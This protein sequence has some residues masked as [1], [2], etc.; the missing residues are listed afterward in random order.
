VN[1]A[2]PPHGAQVLAINSGSSSIR[3]AVYASAAPWRRVLFG[4]LERI[5]SVAATLTVEHGD[6]AHAGDPARDNDHADGPTSIR[7]R[8]AVADIAV[9]ALAD[10]S[11][12]AEFLLGWL[13]KAIDM[14]GL[15]AVGHRLVHGFRHSAP[16][17]VD[18][19]LRAELREISPLAPEHLP[20]ALALID[21]FAQRCPALPQ[22]ACFDT[23]FHH[24]MPA[25]AQRLPIPRRFD[26]A[27]VRRFGFHGL[28]YAYLHDE[29]ERIAGADVADGQLVLAQ[30]GNGASLAA[31]SMGRSVDTSMGFSPNSGLMMGTRSGDLDPGLMAYLAAREGLSTAQ[32]Q[33][34]C[35][36]QS[37][38]LGVSETSADVRELLALEA[39]DPRAAEA[40]ALFCYR[41]RKG[42]G[43]FAAVLGGI[44]TLVFSGGIGEHAAPI[45]GRICSGLQFL[46]IELCAERNARGAAVIS[47]DDSR[48][49][50]RV[51]RT[52][53]EQMIARSTGRALGLRP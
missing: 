20:R 5:G 53:E 7:T 19:A 12:A 30:L 36:H 48:V 29:L 33:N 14:S 27:G 49:C 50:V 23:A 39:T 51:M 1:L 34:L 26:A 10:H 21:A 3:F 37:G 25:L 52:D 45:R 32:L 28:S 15:A 8:A 41:V 6:R 43:G 16:V 42:I 44:D 31:L 13:S 38:L 47:T 2:D 22:V 4:S 24:N 9:P 17:H 46:G 11:A 40:L 35:S 18:A